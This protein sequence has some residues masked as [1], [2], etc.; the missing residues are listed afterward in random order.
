VTL[1]LH[2]GHDECKTVFVHKNYLCR[3]SKYFRAAL[4]NPAFAE[5]ES[6]EVDLEETGTE[7]FDNY[8]HWVY[9]GSIPPFEPINLHQLQD[10]LRLWIFA[11]KYIVPNLQNN[12]MSHMIKLLNYIGM[13][14]PIVHICIC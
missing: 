9:H 10:F 1:N 2:Y 13:Y 8:L 11:D 4:N 7:A 14:F 3:F 5:A 12:V 6:Q